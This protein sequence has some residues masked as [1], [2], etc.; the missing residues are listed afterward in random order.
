MRVL[1]LGF[2]APVVSVPEAAVELEA[3]ASAPTEESPLVAR[4]T[5]SFLVCI[6]KSHGPASRR[7]VA[8]GHTKV[9]RS[10]A[11]NKKA[12]RFTLPTSI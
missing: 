8:S 2:G 9:D 5:L 4:A 1:A 7:R 3:P 12:A 10:D 11:L 6:A